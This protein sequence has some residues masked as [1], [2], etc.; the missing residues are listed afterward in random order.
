MKASVD[1]FK[2]VVPLAMALRKQGMYDRHWDAL[3]KASGVVCKPDPENLVDFKLQKLVDLGMVAHVA[4]CEEI[5]EKAN[6]E[7]FIE[8]SLKKM[9]ADWNGLVFLTP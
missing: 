3:E 4:V 6:K 5:G 9:K 7:Y 8:K 1:T 2:P